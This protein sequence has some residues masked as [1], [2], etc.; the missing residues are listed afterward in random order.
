[1]GPRQLSLP[2]MGRGLNLMSTPD[3]TF[4]DEVLAHGRKQLEKGWTPLSTAGNLRARYGL[5]EACGKRIVGALMAN[6]VG[7][8]VE[9]MSGELATA[10]KLSMEEATAWVMEGRQGLVDPDDGSTMVLEFDPDRAP[11]YIPSTEEIPVKPTT[12]GSASSGPGTRLKGPIHL[13]FNL[14]R[15]DSE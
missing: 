7:R 2:P 3:Q 6:R 15:S 11:S 4:V 9:R 14:L 10:L 12:P 8:S 5:T 13:E 1:M